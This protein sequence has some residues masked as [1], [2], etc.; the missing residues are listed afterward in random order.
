M[1][2]TIP[3]AT[4]QLGAAMAVL[5]AVGVAAA[6][7]ACTPKPQNFALD[8][9]V[10][11]AAAQPAEVT[12]TGQIAGDSEVTLH[13]NGVQGPVLAQT[14]ADAHTG[15]FAATFE[16]PES[17]EPGVAYVVASTGN[18]ASQGVARAALQ[19]TGQG[20]GADQTASSAW[21]AEPNQATAATSPISPAGLST[22]AMA[23]MGM[24][25]L[26]GAALLASFTTAA[27]QRRRTPARRVG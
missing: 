3:W 4:I 8:P 5:A 7:W 22:P 9:P 1:S 18:D 13:W 2:R 20:Q 16:V 14:T 17:A 6:A 10:A 11:A 21:Q 26:G 12:A 24:L 23:G 19:V 15:Q 25:A 27:V